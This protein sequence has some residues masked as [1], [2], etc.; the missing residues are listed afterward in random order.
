MLLAATEYNGETVLRIC[1]VT[2]ELFSDTDE[3][4]HITLLSDT[5][6]PNYISEQNMTAGAWASSW[7]GPVKIQ[8]DGTNIAEIAEVFG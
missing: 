4:R 6:T 7:N 3:E 2:S 8:N 1:L 5:Y